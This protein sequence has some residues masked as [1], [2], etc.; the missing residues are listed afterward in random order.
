MTDY[1]LPLALIVALCGAWAVFQL[2]LEKHDPDARR[3]STK[4]GA[5]S[6]KDECAEP[7]K[8]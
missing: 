2:W 3:R 8:Q 4:C 7:R 1:L 5:C 6:R